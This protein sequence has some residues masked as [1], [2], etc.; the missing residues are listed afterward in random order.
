V[1]LRAFILKVLYSP[2]QATV[3]IW[4]KAE[5]RIESLAPAHVTGENDAAT[6]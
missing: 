6:M 3:Y 1:G 5:G 4:F 2:C